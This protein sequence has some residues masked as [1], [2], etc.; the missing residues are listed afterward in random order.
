MDK[1]HPNLQI[2]ELT[3]A[4]GR[5]HEIAVR[6]VSYHTS[7]TLQ[8]AVELP[9][10]PAWAVQAEFKNWETAVDLII[11]DM[12]AEF[13]S[14]QGDRIRAYCAPL[15]VSDQV[16]PGF[17]WLD[18]Q[19]LITVNECWAKDRALDS[20][21]DQ[22]FII[23]TK[24]RRAAYFVKYPLTQEVPLLYLQTEKA[25]DTW[26]DY[27]ESLEV[28]KAPKTV[29]PAKASEETFGLRVTNLNEVL[30][31]Q[32]IRDGFLKA[33]A[34][35]EIG[36][37]TN[38]WDARELQ[39]GYQARMNY[40]QRCKHLLKNPGRFY[41]LEGIL[42]ASR[43]GLG[44]KAVATN[45][46]AKNQWIVDDSCRWRLQ[47]KPGTTDRSTLYRLLTIDWNKQSRLEETLDGLSFT[48]LSAKRSTNQTTGAAEV[49]PPRFNQIERGPK[50]RNFT[51]RLE[52]LQVVV[53][54]DLP[55]KDPALPPAQILRVYYR[56]S[57]SFD[58]HPVA[59]HDERREGGMHQ[60]W[61][62][63]P[64][65]VI[66]DDQP[67][68]VTARDMLE[69]EIA[70]IRTVT[71]Q[72]DLW[73]Q[74]HGA[75]EEKPAKAAQLQ[76]ALQRFV[77]KYG[78]PSIESNEFQTMGRYVAQRAMTVVYGTN[79]PEK[80]WDRCQCL[81][82]WFTANSQYTC[83]I[84]G[85]I[86][87]SDRPYRRYLIADPQTLVPAI[88]TDCPPLNRCSAKRVGEIHSQLAQSVML[89]NVSPTFK[90]KKVRLFI[91][92]DGTR[93]QLYAFPSGQRAQSI[94]GVFLPQVNDRP[95]E[96]H[97]V[98][99]ARNYRTLSGEERVAFTS[100]ARPTIGTGKL[101][102]V[103]GMKNFCGVESNQ[104]YALVPGKGNVAVDFAI[105]QY[106]LMTGEVVDDEGRIWKGKQC[107][108]AMLE[109]GSAVKATVLWNGR[110]VA[111]RLVEIHMFRT[112]TASENTR[113]ETRVRCATGIA[114]HCIRAALL[115]ELQTYGQLNTND[116][117][118][119]DNRTITMAGHPR[120]KPRD[121]RHLHMLQYAGQV[122]G[123]H[124]GACKSPAPQ[125]MVEQLFG[126]I[127]LDEEVHGS[128]VSDRRQ[129]PE[130]PTI[131]EFSNEIEITDSSPVI[132]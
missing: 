90:G 32:E 112:T 21:G 11:R 62:L 43:G 57:F 50:K 107:L 17:F 3:D 2:I 63:P 102:T 37:K 70:G 59:L 113:P 20:D 69:D 10:L 35:S 39:E 64:V 121:L 23:W 80:M 5:T 53:W 54:E 83:G 29:S 46:P 131:Q 95:N 12:I 47:G 89:G 13:R 103:H 111:G 25:G 120:L 8:G 71:K 74:T 100:E 26:E 58:P 48:R 99:V 92:G 105:S 60:E 115:N 119:W 22:A 40:I 1:N 56:K 72:G 116:W 75:I 65:C 27:Q 55:H 31:E 110:R 66:K 28:W 125:A 82:R 6:P 7:Y 61:L 117:V 96:D 68:W 9:S 84:L 51:Q 81:R 104:L 124:V 78:I 67:I 18:D 127:E 109:Q 45:A 77:G 44:A 118:N 129:I 97:G 16:L 14:V 87:G 94:P 101:I 4:R 123:S 114:K 126:E 86:K 106:E 108:E 41:E 76:Q 42:K 79:I 128:I 33:H 88:I 98:T 91:Y 19:G 15:R 30:T 36:K 130:Q 122:I 34:A 73:P 132:A 38:A 85:G 52:D 49:P 24:D 93:G